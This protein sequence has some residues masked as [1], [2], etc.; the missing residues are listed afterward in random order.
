MKKHFYLSIL[1]VFLFFTSVA[2]KLTIENIGEFM[3]SGTLRVN[4]I[5]KDTVLEIAHSL[6]MFP[7]PMAWIPGKD[8]KYPVNGLFEVTGSYVQTYD[9][10]SLYMV[11]MVP[12]NTTN[13]N[14]RLDKIENETLIG[15][16]LIPEFMFYD[17]QNPPK[18]PP[19]TYIHISRDSSRLKYLF[20]GNNFV[21]KWEVQ[22]VEGYTLPMPFVFSVNSL[23]E[24]QATAKGKETYLS[25]KLSPGGG[26][27]LLEPG[28]FSEGIVGFKTDENT[29]EAYSDVT[30]CR[31]LI[32]RK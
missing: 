19:P 4:S 17:P 31:F 2:Q 10:K 22:K 24:V 3:T 8:F 21:G 11:L 32:K 23:G 15:E 9:E 7:Y 5:K 28:D 13:M 12:G 14:F 1:T 30:H 26:Y 25:Y 16:L 20:T 29:I 27:I 6:E 18:F